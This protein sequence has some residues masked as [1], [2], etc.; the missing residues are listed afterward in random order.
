M[1]SARSGPRAARTRAGRSPGRSN[2]PC[3]P[4]PALPGQTARA[5]PRAVDRRS[6]RFPFPGPVSW[7][8]DRPETLYQPVGTLPALMAASTPDVDVLVV[9]AGITGIYQL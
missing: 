3:G 2:A 1:P 9:G 4:G 7:Q 8:R 6:P 5:A